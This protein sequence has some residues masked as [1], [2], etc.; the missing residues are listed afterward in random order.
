M[1][2]AERTGLG[3]RDL[4]AADRDVGLALDVLLD[5]RAIVHLVDM[6]AGQHDHPAR[7][8]P[9]ED[10]EVLIDSVGGAGVPLVVGGALARRQDVE[11]LVA[12]GTQEAPALLQVPD[13]AVRLVLGGDADPPDARV[14]GVRQREVDDPATAAEMHGGLGAAVGEFM[15]P[16]AAPA[17]QDQ[18]ERV[19]GQCIV[20]DPADAVSQGDGRQSHADLLNPAFFPNSLNVDAGSRLRRCS[21]DSGRAARLPLASVGLVA[22]LGLGVHRVEAGQRL[23]R[24]R[25]RP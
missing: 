12:R 3:T 22:G 5:H 15:E 25:P 2:D 23:R 9:L 24:A 10:V 11:A 13:Q 7:R 14:D 17:G 1:H 8:V 16:R 4:D 6:V 19:A 21:E 18:G 20:P